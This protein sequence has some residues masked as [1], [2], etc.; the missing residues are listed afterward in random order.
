MGGFQEVN[1]DD[2]LGK[3]PKIPEI[4]STAD[5]TFSKQRVVLS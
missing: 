4:V 3:K 5:P 1:I 2:Q